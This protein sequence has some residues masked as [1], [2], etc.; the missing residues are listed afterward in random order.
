MQREIYQSEKEEH[1][2]DRSEVPISHLLDTLGDAH[3]GY[4]VNHVPDAATRALVGA[5]LRAT[6][7]GLCHIQVIE[8]RLEELKD[9]NGY[10]R[11]Q[12]ERFMRDRE[13]RY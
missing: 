3:S 12:L 2:A 10:L 5:L 7:D 8:Q 4:N 11:D 6:Y 13:G 1:R 9:E